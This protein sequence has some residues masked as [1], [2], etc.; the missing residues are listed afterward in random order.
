MHLES[1]LF[2]LKNL[3]VWYVRIFGPFRIGFLWERLF[4]E[5]FWPSRYIIGHRDRRIIM[6]DL[7]ILPAGGR[8]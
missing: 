4:R 8:A 5:R 6:I 7:Y 3:N 2:Y 1:T